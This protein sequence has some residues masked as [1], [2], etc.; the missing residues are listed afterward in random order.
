MGGIVPS[1]QSTGRPLSSPEDIKK[2]VSA[3][4]QMGQALT[5][6]VA[7]ATNI[8]G[9]IIFPKARVDAANLNNEPGIDPAGELAKI[10]DYSAEERKRLGAGTQVYEQK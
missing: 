10:L 6:A 8:A 4:Q 3:N 9:R 2:L 5:G 7:G 1:E